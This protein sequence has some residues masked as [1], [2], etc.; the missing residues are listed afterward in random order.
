MLI[1]DKNRD[2]LTI[3]ICVIGNQSPRSVQ[4]R[5][6]HSIFP[7]ADYVANV[8]VCCTESHLSNITL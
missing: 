5:P 3:I 2:I 8:S 1:L 6:F 4:S 7:H